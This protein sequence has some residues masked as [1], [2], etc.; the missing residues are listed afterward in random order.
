[1]ATRTRA[2]PI[3]LEC[4]R[5]KAARC[6]DCGVAVL[7]C[8]VHG[9]PTRIDPVSINLHGE[10][11]ALLAGIDTYA[12]QPRRDIDMEPSLRS[13]WTIPDGLPQ[14]G[15]IHA[16]HRCGMNWS[17]P[18]YLDKRRFHE[19]EYNGAEAPF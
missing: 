2:A 8:H 19:K 17:Q 15:R 1:M 7:F 13:R 14:R 5:P 3:H 12:L 6:G 4:T 11:V 18:E 9:E 10:L 16:R